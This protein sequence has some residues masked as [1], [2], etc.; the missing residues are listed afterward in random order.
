MSVG[1]RVGDDRVAEIRLE[2]PQR[3]NA[4]DL[5]HARELAAHIAECGRR[6]DIGAILLSAEGAAFCAGGDIQ[7]F[8]AEIDRADAAIERMVEVVHPAFREVAALPMPVLVAVNGPTAG[9][10]LSLVC[11]ADLAIAAPEASFKVAYT[12]IGLSPDGGSS[13]L[14]PRLVGRAAAADLI[15]TNRVLD[16]AAALDL[17]LVSRVVPG[18]E[19]AARSRQLAARIAA[20]SLPAHAAVRRLLLESSANSFERQL[21]R[22]GKEIVRLAGGEGREGIAAFLEKRPASFR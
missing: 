7:H 22:E 1:F 5:D 13:W 15:L 21:D 19:L 6:D 10:G 9:I 20:G 17:G 12:A 3:A 8:G 14:L 16:A 4:L 11:L 2:R 18:S